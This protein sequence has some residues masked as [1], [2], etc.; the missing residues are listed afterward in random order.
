[1]GVICFDILAGA[2]ISCQESCLWWP[3]R[4]PMRCHLVAGEHIGSTRSTMSPDA[5]RKFG[6]IS[7]ETIVTGINL[8][9]KARDKFIDV[10]YEPP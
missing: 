3:Q 1:M 2:A 5:S 9:V 7:I 4:F 8:L 10:C 6:V